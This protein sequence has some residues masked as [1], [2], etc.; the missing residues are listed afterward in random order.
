MQPGLG[1][2]EQVNDDLVVDFNIT[3]AEE[4]LAVGVRLDVRKHLGIQGLGFRV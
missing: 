2:V 4:E 1:G 3:Q